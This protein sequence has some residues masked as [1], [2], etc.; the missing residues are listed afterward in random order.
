MLL[1]AHT[2]ERAL[3]LG[4]KRVIIKPANDSRLCFDYCVF[5]VV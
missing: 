4:M 2:V 3:S 5:F 1:F